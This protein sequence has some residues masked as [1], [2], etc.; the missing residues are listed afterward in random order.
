MVSRV[1]VRFPL[2]LFPG[3]N[4]PQ[5]PIVL[6]FEVLLEPSL[7][8]LFPHSQDQGHSRGA[9]IQLGC[10]LLSHA[11]GLNCLRGNAFLLIPLFGGNIV[12]GFAQKCNVS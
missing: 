9:E 4:L 3:S 10:C 6:S 7:Q 8:S 2:S 12:S 11:C 1:I 5:S